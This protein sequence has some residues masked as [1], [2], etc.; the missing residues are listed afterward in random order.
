LELAV[1]VYNMLQQS[2]RKGQLITR[3]V[4]AR[5]GTP[6]CRSLP[7]FL[8]HQTFEFRLKLV[9]LSELVFTKLCLNVETYGR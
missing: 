3:L 7:R 4:N 8:L 1:K 9:I 5:I 6:A 2:R